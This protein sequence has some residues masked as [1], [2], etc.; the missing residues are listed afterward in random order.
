[1]V[2]SGDQTQEQAE[3]WAVREYLARKKG[4]IYE[5]ELAAKC[6]RFSVMADADR[7]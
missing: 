6:V 1:M 4:A 2:S 7:A 3:N 5:A